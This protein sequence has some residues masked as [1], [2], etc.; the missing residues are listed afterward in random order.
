[1][2]GTKIS[3]DC[4]FNILTD[5]LTRTIFLC[6]DE[7]IENLPSNYFKNLTRFV[8]LKIGKKIYL[9]FNN[10]KSP[11]SNEQVYDE[12]VLI[13]PE[14]DSLGIARDKDFFKIMLN[15]E[16][17][18]NCIRKGLFYTIKLSDE[19][20]RYYLYE[21]DEKQRKDIRIV[22]PNKFVKYYNE[23]EV[24]DIRDMRENRPVLFL[25]F[26]TKI[27]SVNLK[28]ARK[29]NIKKLAIDIEKF[30]I[31]FISYCWYIVIIY[32]SNI[33]LNM[34]YIG[35]N[36]RTRGYFFT[37]PHLSLAPKD[38]EI[39]LVFFK[40]EFRMFEKIYDKIDYFKTGTSFYHKG[41]TEFNRI[42][43]DI[44]NFRLVCY[45]LQ[46][47]F[48][49]NFDRIIYEIDENEF[50]FNC[51]L[52]IPYPKSLLNPNI[53]LLIEAN[54]KF[55]IAQE[56]R[57]K[58]KHLIKQREKECKT[59]MKLQ[60]EAE[61][62][63]LD[64]LKA[65]AKEIAEEA[66][67]K[68]ILN[69]KR[70]EETKRQKRIEANSFASEIISSILDDVDDIFYEWISEDEISSEEESQVDSPFLKSF[71]EDSNNLWLF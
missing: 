63:I 43:Q 40:D 2:Q 41:E 60:K 13:I 44:F 22:V 50:H 6:V 30:D 32:Y 61:R 7:K 35:G 26:F 15:K 20:P 57:D 34:S 52:S 21:D 66:Q 16:V 23:L 56:E 62:K 12:T 37:K 39:Y 8:H 49:K 42:M 9:I 1:M 28:F 55:L 45:R 67:K 31:E 70:I 4:T 46:P 18:N 47:Y 25:N 27:L 68:Y 48:N 17:I 3:Q 65:I 69:E 71:N 33:F 58:L 10:G 59:A 14:N 54:T 36:H 38:K 64:K 5:F 19:T 29:I 11:F 53:D 51:E 24:F